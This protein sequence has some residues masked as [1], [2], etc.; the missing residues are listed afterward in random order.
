MHPSKTIKKIKKALPRSIKG[1]TKKNT[2]NK[3]MNLIKNPNSYYAFSYD[4]KNMWPSKNYNTAKYYLEE[5]SINEMNES[6][7]AKLLQELEA[8]QLNK[9]KPNEL[10]ELRALVKYERSPERGKIFT[11]RMS[12][13][14]YLNEVTI[15]NRIRTIL[16]R[17]K[18]LE[19]EKLVWRGQNKVKRGPRGEATEPE[20]RIEPV[21][22]FSTSTDERIAKGYALRGRC[23]FKIHLMPGVRCFDL[24][25]LYKEY[26][27]T[28]PYKELKKVGALLHS[29]SYK[30]NADYSQYGEVIVEEGGKFY[31][32]PE[33]SKEGF[34][35]IGTDYRTKYPRMTNK[36]EMI[37]EPT[38]D[39]SVLDVFETWYAPPPEDYEASNELFNSDILF[40]NVL[41][42]KNFEDPRNKE[43]MERYKIRGI[44]KNLMTKKREQQIR[45]TLKKKTN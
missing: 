13:T 30:T 38:G 16:A 43:A 39:I 20:C 29:P 45:K 34:K 14:G 10:A 5:T 25:D 40:G 21:S 7:L 17:Q 24:Y 15:E 27:M 26:G 3:V 12:E 9:Y 37:F 6:K 36:G 31:K 4:D 2:Y 11:G 33:L 28:N 1:G 22:W 42:N 19:K 35:Y 8:V 32:D 41:N 18:P 23:L 44:Y